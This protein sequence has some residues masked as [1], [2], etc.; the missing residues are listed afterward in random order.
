MFELIT[1]ADPLSPLSGLPAGDHPWL[2]FS[3][4]PVSEELAAVVATQAVQWESAAA[5]WHI[6]PVGTIGNLLRHRLPWELS[7]L[8][9]SPVCDA[10][11]L[12]RR[13]A[14]EAIPAGWSLWQYLLSLP[15]D[16]VQIGDTVVGHAGHPRR[17]ELAPRT[18][19]LPNWLKQA[20]EAFQ[21]QLSATEETALRAGIYQL[22]DQLDRSHQFSQSIEGRGKHQN[23]DY[24]HAIMHRRE[25]DYSNS[26]YWFRH[27][28]QHPVFEELAEEAYDVIN[29][30]SAPHSEEWLKKLTRNGW[31]PAAFVDLCQQ[32]ARDPQSPLAVAAREIQWR[33]ML[34]L[35]EQTWRDG[36]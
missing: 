32:C 17:P 26:K 24:W 16:A 22:H 1:L 11:I 13:S 7:R 2:L 33:E 19:S 27:V 31:D 5:V 25:P 20:I 21:P 28:G 4:G 34:L 3:S 29:V 30:I 36:R 35:L 12:C 23:G 8:V 6:I 10:V 14:A 9:A 15:S 18:P